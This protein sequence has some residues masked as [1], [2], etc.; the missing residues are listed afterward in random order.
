ML[1]L[2]STFGKLITLQI[3]LQQSNW[4]EQNRN[5]ITA[6]APKLKVFQLINRSKLKLFKSCY[7]YR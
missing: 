4:T 6:G 1:H 7:P 3:L 5:D 2:A